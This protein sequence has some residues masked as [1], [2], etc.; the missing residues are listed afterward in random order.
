MDRRAWLKSSML[1]S[2]ALGLP[3]LLKTALGQDV[4]APAVTVSKAA[5]QISVAPYAPSSI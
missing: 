4:E 2:A 3:T 1:G 5:R